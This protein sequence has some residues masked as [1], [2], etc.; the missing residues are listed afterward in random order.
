MNNTES[1]IILVP[2]KLDFS[3]LDNFY[4]QMTNQSHDHAFAYDFQNTGF[5]TPESII[6]LVTSS[7]IIN[8]KTGLPVRWKNVTP[9]VRGYMDRIAIND[10]SFIN[11]EHPSLFKH[12][13][14]KKS[15]A[16]IE[17]STI[18]SPDQI[19]YAIKQT[20]KIFEHWFPENPKN[21]QRYLTTLIKETV[22]NSIDHSSE[23][24]S[25]GYCYYVLQ[26]YSH[27]DGTT[28]ISIAVGDIGIGMLASQRRK[29]PSTKDD[30]EAIIEA[31]MNGRTARETGGGMGYYT[32]R[33]SLAPL[34]G[35]LTIR[36]GRGQ[37]KYYSETDKP[38]IYRHHVN[39]PGTQILF[40]CRA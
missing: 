6:I 7:K 9:D 17:L 16:L 32:I 14:Y 26:K 12:Q 10:L 29:Y 4:D 5:V 24:P 20:R 33:D 23:V 37:I 34:K 19:G 22:E 30:A 11:L 18:G 13:S 36:S 35:T 27:S 40:R 21:C 28:E 2:D 3:T 39:Y 15:D 38:K 25:M 1:N 8:N 31:L